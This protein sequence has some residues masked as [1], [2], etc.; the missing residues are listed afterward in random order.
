M[1]W[2]KRRFDIDYSVTIS[3]EIIEGFI[4]KILE[5][6]SNF[7]G[8]AEKPNEIN[9]KGLNGEIFPIRSKMVVFNYCDRAAIMVWALLEENLVSIL[10]H[11]RKS[12]S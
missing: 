4:C 8:I 10:R 2:G 5:S 6:T 7:P 11:L 3:D 12:V 1:G 9:S